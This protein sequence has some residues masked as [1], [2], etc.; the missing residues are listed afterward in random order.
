MLHADK[1]HYRE[2]C[3]AISREGFTGAANT[4]DAFGFIVLMRSFQLCQ[5]FIPTFFSA[6][7]YKKVGSPPR[8]L[9]LLKTSMV[10]RERSDR[11]N[12]LLSF[13]S[14]LNVKSFPRCQKSLSLNWTHISPGGFIGICGQYYCYPKKLPEVDNWF[15][16]Y[17]ELWLSESRDQKQ[18]TPTAPTTRPRENHTSLSVLWYLLKC[19]ILRDFLLQKFPSLFIW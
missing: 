2:L 15:L 9:G 14:Q 5:E 12:F 6:M 16:E 8:V 11:A 10:T 13:I 19:W 4:C 1:I 3:F 7:I 17:E 18:P